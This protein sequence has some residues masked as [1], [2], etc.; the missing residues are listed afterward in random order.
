MALTDQLVAYWKTDESSGNAS[1]ST[2]NA[3]TLTNTNTVTY[4]A[5]KINNTARFVSGSSQK[6]SRSYIVGTTAG[7]SISISAWLRIN[8]AP[9]ANVRYTLASIAAGGTSPYIAYIL[10]YEDSGGT[11][12]LW[13][14][15]QK[16]AVANAENYYNTTLTTSTFYHLVLTYDGT[17]MTLYL[18]GS[19]V[20]SQGQTGNGT[21]HGGA[22]ETVV[23]AY[24]ASQGNF[25]DGDIDEIGVWSRALSSTEVTSL[26]NSGSGL[27]YPFSTDLS[28]S[29]SDQVNI[30]ESVSMVLISLINT[31]DQ[32]NIS[33]SVLRLSILNINVNDQITVTDTATVESGTFNISVSDQI[34]VS[35][36]VTMLIP[37]LNINI[38]DQLTMTESVS[39][40]LAVDISVSDQLN[41]TESVSNILILN[42]N[43]F[44]QLSVSESVSMASILNISVS[45]QLTITESK[46]VLPSDKVTGLI[47][48]R[49]QDQ[50]LPV[51]FTEQ[52]QNLPILLTKNE[53]PLGMTDQAQ[54]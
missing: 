25:M 5:G 31:S 53:Y 40:A 29:V 26:Y 32:L 37:F 43:V 16:M 36:S 39:T 1:D 3:R 52:D 33:E 49:G 47:V 17:T 8:N 38:S 22:D 6:L 48:L 23:G 41:I 10:G 50:S 34:N 42:V 46:T 51:T 35:E 44:D 12:R 45:D 18:N 2:A 7:G 13:I 24:H 19:S 14:N 11:K 54:M 15:R 4:V 28:I 20:I 9:G 27:A 21:A 30:T